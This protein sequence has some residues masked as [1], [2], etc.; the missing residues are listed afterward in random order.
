MF[1]LDPLFLDN[2]GNCVGGNT[3]K[4]PCKKDCNG[5]YGGL[6]FIDDC[7]RCVEGNSLLLS[8]RMDYFENGKLKA[9]YHENSTNKL[10]YEENYYE[11]GDVRNRIS[12]KESDKYNINYDDEGRLDGRVIYWNGNSQIKIDTEYVNGKL[13]RKTH[14]HYY[15]DGSISKKIVM[16]SRYGWVHGYEKDGYKFE[17]YKCDRYGVRIK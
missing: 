7:N 3:G 17:K 5:D 8:C 6:A 14:Y 15:L 4:L 13:S 1:C 11:N 9:I 10:L 16:Y 2:C 12:Y